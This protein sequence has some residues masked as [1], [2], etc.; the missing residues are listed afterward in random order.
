[1]AKWLVPGLCAAIAVSTIACGEGYSRA[2][3]HY[4]LGRELASE[5]DTRGAVAEYSEALR[6]EPALTAAHYARGL[7][8]LQLGEYE[9]AQADLTAAISLDPGLTEAYRYRITAD[10]VTGNIDRAFRDSYLLAALRAGEN[11]LVY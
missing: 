3:V 5:G 10:M 2:E 9:G 1:M 8:W 6:L 7:A 4:N 11:L